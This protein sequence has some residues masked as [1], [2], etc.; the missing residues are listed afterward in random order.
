MYLYMGISYK[1]YVLHLMVIR[2]WI[3]S[4][5]LADSDECPLIATY[6]T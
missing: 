2:I 3:T 6:T 4:G 5:G 1:K